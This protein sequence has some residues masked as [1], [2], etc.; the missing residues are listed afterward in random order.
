[1]AVSGCDLIAVVVQRGICL[2]DMDLKLVVENYNDEL[3]DIDRY[4]G[5]EVEWV[6]DVLVVVP[7]RFSD[8]MLAYIVD[9]HKLRHVAHYH[10]PVSNDG[11][12]SDIKYHEGTDLLFVGAAYTDV[13]SGMTGKVTA[14]GRVYIFSFIDDRFIKHSVHIESEKPTE[15][16]LFGRDIRLCPEGILIEGYSNGYSKTKGRLRTAARYEVTKDEDGGPVARV[17]KSFSE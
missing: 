1:V 4:N 14:G 10:H 12:G 5:A 11:F 8:A 7:D 3:L 17:L 6:N 13:R 16:G 2:F 15:H 9:G